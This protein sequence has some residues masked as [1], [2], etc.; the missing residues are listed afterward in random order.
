[1]KGHLAL[2]TG[3]GRGIGEAIARRL[4]KEGARVFITSRTASELERVA[5]EIGADYDICDVTMPHQVE[6]LVRKLGP[7]RIL[8]NNAGIAEAAPIQRM[9]VDLWHRIM[10]T[11]VTSTF[12]FCKAILPGMIDR[13]YGRIV[14]ISSIAGKR[15]AA[16]ITA[17]AASKH[18]ILG[19]T[20]SLAAEVQRHGIMVNAVCPGY[21]NTKMTE[22]N[23]TRI[24]KATKTTKR[25]IMIKLMG[26]AGQTKLLQ[27]SHVAEVACA[28]ARPECLHTGAS[29]DL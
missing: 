27:P 15:G 22:L 5:R 24:A 2:V 23:V 17:Y 18:A 13:G 4:A 7:V 19:F 1:M 3:G 28:L 16:Y 12:L 21:V 6:R 9:D 11:N 25:E 10:D 14:N 8:V 20:S 26:T 29:I